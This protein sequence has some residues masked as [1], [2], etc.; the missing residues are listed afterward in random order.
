[1]EAWQ[2]LSVALGRRYAVAVLLRLRGERR[3]WGATEL[4]RAVGGPVGSAISTSRHLAKHGLV[5]VKEVRGVAGKPA[6]EIRLTP[7]GSSLADGLARL[8]KVL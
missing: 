7:R 4:E 1:M 3:A 5:V 6:Y 2:T 8:V